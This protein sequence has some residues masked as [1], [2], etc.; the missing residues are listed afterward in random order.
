MRDLV[1]KLLKSIYKDIM[2][3]GFKFEVKQNYV[4]RAY[5]INF[6]DLDD[7]CY[8]RKCRQLTAPDCSR[9]NLFQSIFKLYS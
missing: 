6:F 3:G 8:V 5:H 7:T 2:N 1:S 4:E 9:R